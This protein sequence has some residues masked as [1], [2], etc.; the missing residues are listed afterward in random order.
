MAAAANK[1][2]A[3]HYSLIL[4]VMLSVILGI[5]TYMFHRE[6]SDKFAEIA[7]LN[8]ENQKLN[9]V[10]KTLA[11]QIDSLKNKIGIKFDQVDDPN[12]PQN[13]ATVVRGLETEMLTNGK[14]VAGA[15]VFES[16]R[17]LREALD[18][19]S[20]DRD[21]KAA[22]VASLEKE[23]LGLKNQYQ[24]QVDNY[25]QQ[26]KDA[27]RDKLGVIGDRDEKVNAKIQEISSYKAKLNATTDELLQEK[28]SR[29]KE[30]KVLNST[31]SGLNNRIEFLK[32]KIDN[33]EKLS[34]EVAD[35]VIRR[36]EHNT[37]TVWINLGEADY[38]KPRMTFSV[39]AKE[40][41]GV[42]RGAEDIKGKI[43][44]TRIL[45]PHMAECRVIEED[46]YRPMVSGDLIYTPI[47]SP[48][49]IEKISVIGAIDLD[50]DGRSDREQFHQMMA[51]A[52]CVIDNEVDDDGVR[53][54]KDAKI[55]VQTRFLVK[56][57]IPELPDV[58]G[59]EAKKKVKDIQGHFSDMRE[60]ARSNGVRI[61][62]MNDFLAY[63]GYHTKR[64]T[65]IPGQNRPWNLKAG[66][67]SESTKDVSGDRSS[68]GNV[69]GAYTK[70]RQAPQN[71][72][73]GTTSKVF[74]GSK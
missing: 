43:E 33:L 47:W 49:L 58:T 8:D 27:E 55:T 17:K 4:F 11:D 44:V 42:G 35:G 40:N 25:S 74:G 34:F 72:S 41:L 36:V 56:G 14:D 68:N 19:V 53:T 29:E 65:F 39:Y 28:E 60:E 57:D 9:R 10:Q 50:G 24:A 31:I 64:R 2:G 71:Q 52:G 37:N 22:K 18:A 30:R 1:P 46:L 26:T 59:D 54:P 3:V 70:G 32:E 69:S 66:S 38:L 20:A 13:Q 12:N 23:V 73:D 63:I 15:T 7:K 62:K 16:L 6:S 51:V 48:G 21:S 67:A 45:E 61:I 5:T